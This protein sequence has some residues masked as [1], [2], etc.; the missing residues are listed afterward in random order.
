MVRELLL[1]KHSN[2]CIR[3]C[4][5]RESVHQRSKLPS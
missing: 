5:C 3:C 2:I 4:F 1:L